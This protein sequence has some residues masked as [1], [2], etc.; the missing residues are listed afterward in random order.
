M[1]SM[2]A[3]AHN[4]DLLLGLELITELVK[5]CVWKFNF[6]LV[7]FYG[8]PNKIFQLTTLP[9]ERVLE[10]TEDAGTAVR[11]TQGTQTDY[12]KLM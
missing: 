6:S 12:R 9:L 3:Q 2:Q 5:K 10:N 7:F 4:Q 8:Y 11:K 1:T